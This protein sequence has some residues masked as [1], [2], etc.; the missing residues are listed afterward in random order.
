M[1]ENQTNESIKGSELLV[2]NDHPSSRGH[3][4]IEDNQKKTPALPDSLI[5]TPNDLK[6]PFSPFMNKRKIVRKKRAMKPLY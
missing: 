4:T 3:I 2:P 6:A 5:Q 1:A